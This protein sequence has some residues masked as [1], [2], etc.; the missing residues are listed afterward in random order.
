MCRDGNF[1]HHEFDQWW[2][3]T[4]YIYSVIK[5]YTCQGISTITLLEYFTFLK[6]HI[7]TSS[8]K[9]ILSFFSLCYIH[10]ISLVSS[11][12]HVSCAASGFD[13]YDHV[14]SE[15]N[16]SGLLVLTIISENK[17]HNTTTLTLNDQP[18]LIQ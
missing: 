4:K 16:I 7:S 18:G 10:L 9:Q 12:M 13:N 1:A 11:L 8:Q 6:L 2:K 14:K 17:K 5:Y 15:N 3:V